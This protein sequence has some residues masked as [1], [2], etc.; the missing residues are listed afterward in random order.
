MTAEWRFKSWEI[1][2]PN[3][4]SG[5]RRLMPACFRVEMVRGLPNELEAERVLWRQCAGCWHITF[6]SNLHT[7]HVCHWV[8]MITCGFISFLIVSFHIWSS[9]PRSKALTLGPR[10]WGAPGGWW[11]LHSGSPCQTPQRKRCRLVSLFGV[12]IGGL[13]VGFFKSIM[14]A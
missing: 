6:Y 2:N 10:C 8:Y 14:Q 13:D 9:F 1:I 12:W 4:D 7:A 5:L 3:G 11:L